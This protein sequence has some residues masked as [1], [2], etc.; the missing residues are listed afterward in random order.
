MNNSS[1]VIFFH[2]LTAMKKNKWHLLLLPFLCGIFFLWCASV[3]QQPWLVPAKEQR[4]SREQYRVALSVYTDTPFD[5]Q[6]PTRHIWYG[7]VQ[8]GNLIRTAKHLLVDNVSRLVITNSDWKVCPIQHIW[9]HPSEDIALI[10]TSTLCVPWISDNPLTSKNRTNQLFYIDKNLKKTSI[11]TGNG[12]TTLLIADTFTPGM[13]WSPLFLSDQTIVAIV[14]AQIAWWTEAVL[15][16][17]ALL[18]SR[19]EAQQALWKKE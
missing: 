4:H 5:I 8:R 1:Y 16:N 2:Y 6:T 11:T 13:S 14:T 19:A 18:A 12:F 15:I 3:E 17:N 10:Q 9:L 7:W